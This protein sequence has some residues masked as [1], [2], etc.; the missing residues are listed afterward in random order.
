MEYGLIGEHLSHSFSKIIH[1]HISQ[2]PYELKEIKK[3]DLDSFMKKRDFKGINVTIP[4]KEAVIPYLDEI[5]DQALSIGAVNTIVNDH[6]RLKGYNTDFSGMKS[7]MEVAG[8][9]PSGKKVL[10][11]GTGGTSKTAYAVAKSLK[12]ASVQKVSRTAKGGAISYEEAYEYHDDAGIIINTTP[13][14]MYP[15]SWDCPL[16]LSLFPELTGLVDAIYNPLRTNLVLDAADRGIPAAGGLYMLVAQA[17]FAAELFHKRTYDKDLINHIYKDLL[18]ERRNIVLTGMSRAGKSTVGTMLADKLGRRLVDTDQEIIT[19]EKKPITEIFSTQGEEYFRELETQV[20]KALSE[21]KGLVIATGG[22]V[23]LKEENVRVLKRNGYLIFLD[24]PLD[25]I[26]P[27]DDRPLANTL[28]KIINLFQ[29]RYPIYKKTC[30]QRVPNTLSAENVTN[31]ILRIFDNKKKILVINGPNLNMLGIREPDIY[32]YTSYNMLVKMIENHAKE[33]GAE[34][35]CYQSNHEG[36]LVD[37]IQQAYGDVDGIVINPGAYTHTSV[38]LL[39]AL[40][41]VSIPAVEVHISKVD[42]REDFRQIS[43]VRDVC[44]T[45]IS[46]Q[47]LAGYMQAMDLL[48]K[49]DI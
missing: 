26:L 18:F 46:G 39:D 28:D 12:A 23:I 41:A 20:V 17:V 14:G 44:S 32:G 6:G 2:Y 5:S 36:D 16:D 24:R 35:E 49:G 31:K 8:I 34:V 40:K 13:C 48:V 29:Y 30:D 47:G 9:D 22:G 1:E 42:E 21:E 7:L 33:L 3:E 15:N 45:V 11:L 37:R 4:Y 43:Y 38:A 27:T 19:L 25:Q 10:I